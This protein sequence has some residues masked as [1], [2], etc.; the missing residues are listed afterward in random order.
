MKK[1]NSN[2]LSISDMEVIKSV[3]DLFEYQEYKNRG[4]KR[5]SGAFSEAEYNSYDDEWIYFTL[6]IGIQNGNENSVSTEHY[7]FNRNLIKEMR[8]VE[9]IVAM[10]ADE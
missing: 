2:S 9:Y 7:K 8:S 5:I 10:I 1:I 6:E 4:Y 3:L